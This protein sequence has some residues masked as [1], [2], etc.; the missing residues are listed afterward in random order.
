MKDIDF[1][2][3]QI[4]VREGKGEKDRAVPLADRLQA[5]LRKQIE[6]ASHLHAK[7][8]AVGHGRVWLPY[9]LKEKFPNAERELAWQYV[10]PSNR[11]SVD[12]RE[13]DSEHP[14]HDPSSRSERV[15]RRHHVHDNAVQKAVRQA[16]LA[17]GLTNKKVGVFSAVAIV[18]CFGRS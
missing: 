15:L 12:P 11:L 5:A 17:S 10:F 4:V 13:P 2:R 6:H 18:C 1:Q 14:V 16:V 3:R 9:A 8:V 7:D